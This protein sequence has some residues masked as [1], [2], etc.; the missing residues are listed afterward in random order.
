M[1]LLNRYEYSPKTDMIGKGAF[2]RVYKAFDRKLNRPVALKIYRTSELSERYNPIAEIQKVSDLDHPNIC[3]YMDIDEIE[4]ENTFGETE[5]IQICVME[6]LDGGNI[7]AYYHTSN[8]PELLKKFIVDVLHGL[9]YLHKKGIIHRDIKP[10]NILIKQTENGPVAKITDFGISKISDAADGHSSALIVSIPYLAPEQLNPQKYAINENIAF[11]LDLWTLGVALYEILTGVNLFRKNEKETPEETMLN[12]QSLDIAEKIKSVPQPF[13]TFISRCLI[14]DAKLRIKSADLLIPVIMGD[15]P[16]ETVPEK[17]SIFIEETVVPTAE[18]LVAEIEPEYVPAIITLAVPEIEEGSD[19]AP[20]VAKEDGPEEPTADIEAEPVTAKADIPQEPKADIDATELVVKTEMPD[21]VKDDMDSTQVIEKTDFPEDKQADIDATQVIAKPNSIQE[22]ALDIDATQVI[23]KSNIT[24][25]QIADID[26]T[27]VIAKTDIDATQIIAK[28]DPDAT[29]LISKPDLDAT[30]LIAK[31]EIDATQLISNPD[32]KKSGTG[33]MKETETDDHTK[34]LKNQIPIDPG[35]E[36]QTRILYGTVP[37]TTTTNVSE[38]KERP[39]LLFS[40]YEYVPNT[41]LIGRGGFSRVYKGYDQKLDRW[42]ALKVYKTGEFSDRYSPISEIRRVINLDHS[43]ICRYLDIE[44]IEKLNHFGENEKMQVCVMELLDGGN[45]A[46]YYRSNRDP[47]ILKKLIRDILYGLSY[48]HKNGIIHRDIKPAN[49]LI[50][51]TIEGPVAKIT[52]FGISKIS[53]SVNNNS[54]SALIVSIPYMAPEQLNPK[55]YGINEKISYNLDLWSL[56][57]TIYE[58]YTGDVL[59]KNSEQDNSEQIMN[60]IM[61]PGLPEKINQLPEPFR[62]VVAHCIM[63]N[64]N[65]RV[66]KAEE[67][68]VLLSA[69]ISPAR[70]PYDTGENPEHITSILPLK[71]KETYDDEIKTT[72]NDTE[73]RERN[74]ILSETA[75]LTP[76]KP[77]ARL[78]YLKI[79]VGIGILFILLIVFLYIRSSRMEQIIKNTQTYN[80]THHLVKVLPKVTDTV[81]EKEPV[82]PQAEIPKDTTAH[83]ETPNP[84]KVAVH[85]TE[86]PVTRTDVPATKADPAATK[87]KEHT[88]V[89]KSQE[90]KTEAA[91]VANGA[92]KCIL[93]LTTTKTCTIKLNSMDI[94]TLEPGKTMKVYLKQGAYLLQAT[95]VSNTSSVYNGNLQI[96][97]DN[98]NTVAKIKI[99]L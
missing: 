85:K 62:N 2:A 58:V 35:S 59:F 42:V 45:F 99:P 25:E 71:N 15:Y 95:S 41:D 57:V 47:E 86:V 74:V 5:Q 39:I 80:D 21:E 34:L 6:L 40:R 84:N 49:I 54:S 9:M 50:K 1:K 22:Q 76:K 91:P 3:R 96:G 88:P 18:V 90:P 12:I 16:E 65:E 70:I 20:F 92:Q 10:T 53:D 38:R 30:Q 93:E 29:Q 4:L 60:N 8:D 89:Q 55:K 43:N 72:V 81:R 78:N 73:R 97:P 69:D 36:D 14:R 28:A 27:Q 11:N 56:G 67:L 46:E 33:H 77:V 94:G 44:E 13:R 37:D 31:T 24:Q 87:K 17:V 51:R 68:L 23:K 79:S 52:D 32:N 64:A 83:S 61:A 19:A 66:K 26:A 7:A 98:I 63:K 48:L 82:I 75:E